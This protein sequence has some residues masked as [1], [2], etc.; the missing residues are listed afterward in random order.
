MNIS[1]V[2]RS[3]I[4]EII[5]ERYKII[6][7]AVYVVLMAVAV[8]HHEPWM[9]EAQAWLLAK[10]T[11]PAELLVKYLRYEGSPG[12]WHLILMIPAKLG[13]PYFTINI[14]S[15]IFA[16]TG[17][18]IFI[19]YSPFPRFIKIL[20]PFTFF[21]FFQYGV[22]ARNYCLISSILFLI[23]ICYPAKKEKPYI[24]ILL[25]CLL[26]N[27]SAHTFLI[28]GSI[29]FVH[30][31]D[32]L[33]D[34]K[35]MSARSR[36]HNLVSLFIFAIMAILVILI[37]ITPPDQIYAGYIK[38]SVE[39]FWLVSKRMIGGSMIMNEYTHNPW[40]SGT[41]CY[42]IFL[43]SVIWFSRNKLM[44]LY[45]LPLVLLCTLFALKYRNLWHQGVLFL[46]WIFVLWISFEKYRDKEL[47]GLA[48]RVIGGLAIAL[49]VQIYWCIVAV[50]YDFHHNYSAGFSV[51]KYIKA[52]KFDKQTIY[53][54][55][56][57]N[58]SILPYFSKNIFYNHNKGSGHRFWNWST[59]NV[60][61]VGASEKVIDTI[62][63][64]QPQLVIFSSD[65]IARKQKIEL[66]GYK[67]IAFFRGHLCWKTGLSEPECYLIFKKLT[68]QE[69]LLQEKD[70]LAGNNIRVLKNSL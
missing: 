27:I 59:S 70:S 14:L 43:S 38:T 1:L 35:N 10:D 54:S 6:T 46:L 7:F 28:A 3:A 47:R 63:C 44:L 66:N 15:A 39:N 56:W 17:V 42:I 32:V 9:D 13:L 20:Y 40:L 37:I 12:L 52:N 68:E 5:K 64:L 69:K 30:F 4:I 55:G 48:K 67:A 58:I 62:E 8:A 61:S 26:A 51:A 22:V 53:A 29:A 25:L 60:T 45:F 36:T 21:V 31:I 18:W 23:A 11:T 33:K 49:A 41:I 24:F 57:K 19:R 2:N 50:T 16:A 34:W 65:H